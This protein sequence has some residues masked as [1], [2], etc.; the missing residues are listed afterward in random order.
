VWAKES[1]A[2]MGTMRPEVLALIPARGGS[3]GIP[4][5]NV[6][7]LC[8]VPLVAYT[9]RAALA[10]RHITRVI[11]STDD[12]EIAEISR[13]YGAEVPFLRPPS[14]AQA[15]STQAD[16]FTHMLAA[17]Q[18]QGYRPQHIVHLCPTS[19]FR[20]PQLIDA[21]TA[22]LI[23]GHRSVMTVKPIPAGMTYYALDGRLGTAKPVALKD[24]HNLYRQ[25][26]IYYGENLTNASKGGYMH[27]V[28]DEIMLI[29]VDTPED[30]AVADAVIR[31]N[32]F[33]FSLPH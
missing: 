2:R 30:L 4:R 7:L 16:A 14:L 26:G 12:E 24:A 8:E 28:E 9:I 5:K 22:R 15:H 17:L 11:V 20:T 23:Q 1:A 19:P 31:E 32:L 27:V 18:S 29:D 13:G 25:Y 6:A 3:K 21:L 10:S 33:N